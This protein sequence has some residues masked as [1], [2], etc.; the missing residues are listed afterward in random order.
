[1]VSLKGTM[2]SSRIGPMERTTEEV[3]AGHKETSIHVSSSPNSE[4]KTKITI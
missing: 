4:V 1:V 2:E 3:V